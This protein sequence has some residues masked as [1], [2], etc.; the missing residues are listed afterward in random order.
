MVTAYPRSC[1]SR[2]IEAEMI[3]LPSDEAT[4]PV[5]NMYFGLL[6]FI[7]LAY[8]FTFVSHKN[9]FRT[10]AFLPGLAARTESDGIRNS[11][12]GSYCSPRSI[13]RTF[14]MAACIS[15]LARSI[16]CRT[17]A[18]SASAFFDRAKKPMLFSSRAISC[19]SWRTLP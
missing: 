7:R 9:E 15:A 11:V 14:S 12:I 10:P 13:R 19:S 8:L 4:P 16:F 18:T 2:A 1:S 3:P 6:S 17:S 5:T